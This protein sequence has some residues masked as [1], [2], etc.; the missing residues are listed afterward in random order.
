[1]Y[2]DRPIYRPGQTVYFRL[3]ARQAYNGRYSPPQISSLPITIF[4]AEGRELKTM[5]LPLYAL[6]T[7]HGEF[8]LP[9]DAQPGNYSINSS[10]AQNTT[11]NFQVA[12]Y[13]KPE[14][15]LEVQ[16]A[17]EQ[18]KAGEKIEATINARYFFGSPAG[19]LPVKWALYTKDENYS[20][21]GYQVGPAD[22]SWMNT[23]L[24]PYFGQ[25]LG[26]MVSQGEAFHGF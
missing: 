18:V 5:D 14:I 17:Q 4:D 2:T 26:E 21:S 12:N 13:R 20:L 11:L 15:N 23:Y 19:N 24:P 3:V 25:S 9:E 22:L 1:M 6:G 10:A 7:A 16:F 8:G